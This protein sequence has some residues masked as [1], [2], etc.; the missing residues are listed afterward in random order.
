MCIRGREEGK[1]KDIVTRE[2]RNDG[3][4]RQST[5]CEADLI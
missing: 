5:N 1:K 3:K 2:L 4:Y